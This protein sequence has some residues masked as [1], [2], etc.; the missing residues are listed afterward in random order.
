MAQITNLELFEE[1]FLYIKNPN[2]T[3]ENTLQEFGGSSFYLPSY[4][5]TYRNNE[6]I[7]NYI[8]RR[9]EKNIIKK[10]AKDFNLSTSQI[11]IITKDLRN[12]K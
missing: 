10:L 3:L 6:I 12:K 9:G 2:N 4:K 7:R 8:D 5:S 11:F 1:L